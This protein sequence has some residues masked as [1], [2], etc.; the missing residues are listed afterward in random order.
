MPEDAED[1][2]PYETYENNTSLLT[3]SRLSKYDMYFSYVSYEKVA[4]LL[5]ESDVAYW[6]GV[7]YLF[8][9]L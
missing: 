3:K 7:E 6:Q 8:H 1:H 2:V 5:F 9:I 4:L